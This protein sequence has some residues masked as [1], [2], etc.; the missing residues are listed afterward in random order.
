MTDIVK[1]YLKAETCFDTIDVFD[2]RDEVGGVWNATLQVDTPDKD[3]K[4]P[5][6]NPNSSPTQPYCFSPHQD[7]DSTN[8]PVFLSPIY[9]SL[10]TNIP[11][12]LMEFSD[13]AFP[14]GCP[15]FP[16][17]Q[18]VLNYLREYAADLRPYLRLGTQV[19]RVKPEDSRGKWRVLT[20]KVATGKVE[21]AVYDA[22][23]VASGHYDDPYIPN[24]PGLAQW[25]ATYP[26]AVTHSKYYR[27]P[28]KYKNKVMFSSPG[29][30]TNYIQNIY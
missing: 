5:R 19:V 11:Y 30:L 14:E 12:T 10:N 2:Q 28:G 1:R 15:I 13:L 24:V 20:K 27:R 4:V 17:H 7:P 21:A 9:D 23:V 29:D 22:V 18:V 26:G 25:S 16:P 8:S 6:T 3:F